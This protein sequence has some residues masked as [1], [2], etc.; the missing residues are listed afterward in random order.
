M[1]T[2][3][4]AGGLKSRE[5]EDGEGEPN[6]DPLNRGARA[7][8][9]IPDD[10][11]DQWARDYADNINSNR[12]WSWKGNM[13]N[14]IPESARASIKQRAVDQGLIPDIPVDTSVTNPGYADFRGHIL[15]EVQMPEYITKPDGTTINLWKATDDVQFRWLNDQVRLT[16]PDYTNQ[17]DA[18]ATWHHHE[19]CGIDE[20]DNGSGR[21]DG[22][23]QLVERGIHNA[24]T[25]SGG[26]SDGLWADAP[27]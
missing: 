11:L 7:R 21:P 20:G 23:M 15:T 4:R 17:G 16:D 8:R 25:H 12:V 26:R 19:G 22:T 2:G 27:R 10:S 9:T 1:Q 24:T 18:D 6:A 13:D 5:G 14:Q 3:D